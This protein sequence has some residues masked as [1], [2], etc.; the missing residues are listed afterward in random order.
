M[1]TF[2]HIISQTLLETKRILISESAKDDAFFSRYAKIHDSHP[3]IAT[4]PEEAKR[5]ILY[6]KPFAANHDEA[7]YLSKAALHNHYRVG[8][9]DFAI[10]NT[11][12]R[13]RKAKKEGKISENM[14][15]FTHDKLNERLNE[16][17][18]PDYDVGD[19]S[20]TEQ[21]GG[22]IPDLKKFHIGNFSDL[23]HGNL[24]V[25]HLGPEHSQKELAHFHRNLEANSVPNCNWCVLHGSEGKRY[26]S[27]YANGHG[28]F[29]YANNRGKFVLAHGHGDRGL[30]DPSNTVV[31]GNHRYH[32]IN[33]TEKLLH[34]SYGPTHK[35]SEDYGYETGLGL[36]RLTPSEAIEKI[37]Y[38]LSNYHDGV[39]EEDDRR[40]THDEIFHQLSD[41][42]AFSPDTHPEILKKL[43]VVHMNMSNSPNRNGTYMFPSIDD[44]YVENNEKKIHQ[45]INHKN[46]PSDLIHYY[47]GIHPNVSDSKLPSINDREEDLS[48][49][50]I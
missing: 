46:A 10:T 21:P 44:N 18:P 6:I 30:V 31:R 50:H 14:A 37:D 24:S 40:M 29:G 13:W 1:K 36:H 33:N 2:K 43:Y 27:G 19:S 12:K 23:K 38:H 28:F 48:L 11:L 35:I 39:D 25:Y 47:L 34:K 45:I 20:R 26:L 41:H 17:D 22:S 9:D 3:L 4:N 15:D 5:R 32:I 42:F 7:T 49:I 8:E 16:I